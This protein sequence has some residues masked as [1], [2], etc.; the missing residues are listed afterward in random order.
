[1][2]QCLTKG[3]SVRG[4]EQKALLVLNLRMHWGQTETDKN[5][6]STVTLRREHL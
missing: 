5:H 4:H 3:K 6:S 2:H 1:M